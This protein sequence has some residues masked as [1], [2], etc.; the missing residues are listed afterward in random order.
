MY[1]VKERFTA[2]ASPGK[3]ILF[4]LSTLQFYS[5]LLLNIR[6]LCYSYR[7]VN[8]NNNLSLALIANGELKCKSSASL[9]LRPNTTAS[10]NAPFNL[11]LSIMHLSMSSSLV[12]CAQYKAI[13]VMTYYV[14]IC[15]AR[16]TLKIHFLVMPLLQVYVCYKISLLYVYDSKI[17]K[18][19]CLHCLYV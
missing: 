17:Y 16:V 3:T 5:L 19:T 6:Y 10:S 14:A 15:L 8:E 13:I 2:S 12:N 4:I 18:I 1:T 9:L 11:H 7:R